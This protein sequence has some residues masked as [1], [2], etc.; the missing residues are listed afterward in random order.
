MSAKNKILETAAKEFANGVHN[1][2]T[3]KLSRRHKKLREINGKPSHRKSCHFGHSTRN[4]DDC[5]T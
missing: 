3:Q 1:S 5:G 4:Q 2:G